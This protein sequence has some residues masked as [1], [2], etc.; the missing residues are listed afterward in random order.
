[1]SCCLSS[2]GEVLAWV[3]QGSWGKLIAVAG[4][5]Y[6]LCTVKDMPAKH[7]VWKIF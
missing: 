5:G 2:C 6:L 1:M 7:N 4:A 3:L